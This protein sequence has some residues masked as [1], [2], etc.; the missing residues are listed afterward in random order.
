MLTTSTIQQ[1][2]LFLDHMFPGN[3]AYN[4][5]SLFHIKG[6]L[7]I[8]A[9]RN[10]LL[11]IQ[12]RHEILRTVFVETNGVFSQNILQ[13][14]VLDFE[15]IATLP[16]HATTAIDNDICRP[17]DTTNG[18]LWR[19][20]IFKISDDECYLLFVMQHA[21]IDLRS[22]ELFSHELEL[23]YNAT[24][25]QKEPQNLPEVCPYSAYSQWE[26]K[27]IQS[28]RFKTMQRHWKEQLA[29]L[30]QITDLPTNHKRPA[31]LQLKGAV[32]ELHLPK[33]TFLSI[34][35]FCAAH[36][37][38]PFLFLQ[39]AYFIILH[40]YSGKTNF[41]SGVPFSN[42][43][44]EAHKQAMGCF[45]NML[46]LPVKFEENTS[47]IDFIKQIRKT[48]LLAHRNQEV[49]IKG[50]INILQPPRDLSHNPLFQTGFTF[51]P[52]MK[53]DLDGLQCKSLKKHNQGAQLDLLATLW[54]SD[55]TISGFFEYNTSLFNECSI[56]RLVANYITLINSILQTPEQRVSTLPILSESEHKTLMSNFN[57]PHVKVDTYQPIPRIIETQANHS[58]E[59]IAALDHKGSISYR[60]LNECSNQ[61][62][63][64]L[65]KQA[66]L[67]GKMVGI[68]MDRSID[69]LIALLAVLKT[70]AAFVPIDPMFPDD[71]ITFM[72]EHAQLD[73]IIT[74][75]HVH[76]LIKKEVKHSISVDDLKDVIAQEDTSNIP[77][78]ITKNSLAYVI[79]TSGS[80]GNPKG[81]KISHGAWANLLSSMSVEPGLSANDRLMAVT[82]LS[83]DI[84]ML[85]LFLPMTVG[86]RVIISTREESMDGSLLLKTIRKHNVTLLQAT[87][88]TWHMLINAGWNK[89]DALRVLCGGESLPQDLAAQLI[90][91]SDDVWNMYGPTETT[92]WSTCQRITNSEAPILVGKPIANT[93]AY[94]LDQQLNP[95]P[96]GSTGSL[97][98]GGA[99]LSQ[100][101]LHAPELTQSVFI[102]SPKGINSKGLIY[103]TGD[104]ARFHE[105]GGLEIL[106]RTDHQIK[107]RGFR[108]EL[109]EIETQ[110]S[111]Y[112]TIKQ[113]IISAIT[114][115]SK[116]K[117]LV[118]FYILH[119][120]EHAVIADLRKHLSRTLPEYMI[121]SYFVELEQMP[122]TPNGKI[123]KKA[124]PRPDLHRPDLGN[125]YVAPGNDLENCITELW[126]NILKIDKIGIHDKFFEMGGNSLLAVQF[127][128]ELKKLSDYDISIMSIFQYPTIQAL[129]AYLTP[130]QTTANE[131]KKPPQR[132]KQ[133][134]NAL[135]EIKK[136]RSNRL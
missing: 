89:Q 72:I 116:D 60:S 31:F 133:R 81:V 117:A 132:A 131:N 93:S 115:D 49:A 4:M 100:G 38:T 11:S 10:S 40:R 101:Y 3:T 55:D 121:P 73:T 94:I 124:L 12:K 108:I 23:F 69:Q 107:I 68:Y 84:A 126:K 15:L 1:Q 111:K 47:F 105:N 44:N 110:L 62:A 2:F 128:T 76:H 59:Q 129:A 58:P 20:R 6:I 75:K 18:P 14:Q 43:R 56:K 102:P 135:L 7:D 34:Q 87:P 88:V 19:T 85:E 92:I 112:K 52:P 17:F 46:P 22:K 77:L 103:N 51:E 80:T 28:D 54:K 99:G 42:R 86:A 71:R 41:I 24:I 136:R 35:Q 66:P 91:R 79:Y 21:I 29:G 37:I 90:E 96:I 8:D 36:Q 127:I 9:L 57:T 50:I 32:E 78:E 67:H 120:G 39:A 5:P 30:N 119:K 95:V 48:M 82:T 25:V 16:D 125:N 106:G 33:E 63:H 53:L 61:L 70:G 64:Y 26:E 97:Y 45:V 98:L 122:L 104:I 130:L 109:D 113:C 65:I 123:D 27:F 118:A 114:R 83:F 134:Q 13:T 74:D